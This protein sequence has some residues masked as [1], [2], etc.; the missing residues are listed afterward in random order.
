MV[1][2]TSI[3]HPVCPIDDIAV[4]IVIIQK[5][6]L[7]NGDSKLNDSVRKEIEL[8]CGERH[9]RT[10]VHGSSDMWETP[11]DS[12]MKRVKSTRCDHC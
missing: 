12:A 8:V 4:V 9:C 11:R 2:V 5:S 10:M 3:Q 1:T 7:L 6:T